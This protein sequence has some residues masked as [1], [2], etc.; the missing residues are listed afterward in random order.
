MIIQFLLDP[1][2]Q[3]NDVKV[4]EN[5]TKVDVEI[6][7]SGAFGSKIWMNVTTMNGTAFG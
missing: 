7:R 5:A 6:K 4:F 1:R 2:I 3:S